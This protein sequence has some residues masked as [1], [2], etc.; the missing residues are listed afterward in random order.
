VINTTYDDDEHVKIP[1]GFYCPECNHMAVWN[2]KKKDW[3]CPICL[4]CSICGEPAGAY[5]NNAQPINEGR[6]CDDCNATKVIPA[7]M[8]AMRVGVKF[9][10]NGDSEVDER[11]VDYGEEKVCVQ[12]QGTLD[13]EGNLCKS[14]ATELDFEMRYIDNNKITGEKCPKC[15][16]S[17]CVTQ[18]KDAHYEPDPKDPDSLGFFQPPWYQCGHCYNEWM[19][20]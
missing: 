8:R 17:D 2:E 3:Y 5:G 1:D 19:G 10:D 18:T 4:K 6:C 9:D 13:K 7:R 15:G 20:I 12:C 14:C 16:K 11:N